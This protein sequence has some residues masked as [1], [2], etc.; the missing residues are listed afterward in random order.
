MGR[1][2]EGWQ[3]QPL[4]PLRVAQNCAFRNLAGRLASPWSHRNLLNAGAFSCELRPVWETMVSVRKRGPDRGL[5]S[6]GTDRRDLDLWTVPQERHVHC[7]C[8][9]DPAVRARALQ[10][11]P[12]HS[13]RG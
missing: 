1:T 13:R 11:V 10:A 4:P 12:A 9:G 2:A 6:D 7:A 8:L 5:R 3:I